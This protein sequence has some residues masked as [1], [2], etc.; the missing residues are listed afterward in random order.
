MNSAGR[1]LVLEKHGIRRF[2]YPLTSVFSAPAG[3]DGS[4]VGLRLPDGLPVPSQV[5]IQNIGGIPSICLDFALSIGPRE[6]CEL[7]ICR[8]TAGTRIDDPLVIEAGQGYRSVQRRFISEFDR[9]GRLLQATYDGRPHLREPLSLTRNREAAASSR[10]P[11]FDSGHLAARLTATGR[12]PDS[13]DCR[14][15]LELTACKSWAKVR[16]V[17]AGPRPGDIVRFDLP[18]AVTAPVLTCDFGIGGG[19]YGRLQ[20]ASR[21]E[22]VWHSDFEGGRSLSWSLRNAGR[23]DFEGHLSLNDWPSAR[24]FHV[25]DREKAL[26]VAITEVPH[27]SSRLD[28]TLNA[29]GEVTIEFELGEK[30]AAPA[31]FAVCYHF[32]NDIPPIAAATNPQSIL[33]PPVVITELGE[34]K[35]H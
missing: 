16:H 6:T 34:L 35:S 25:I 7:Q 14:T 3:F 1:I 12:Y 20:Q 31:A 32:L 29:D 17:L 18:L 23:T 4:A 19:L 8:D 24:W 27:S 33:L 30:P 9:Q 2:L 11:D 5:T 28:V 21:Q 13:C 22:I 26:A 15:T 10:E